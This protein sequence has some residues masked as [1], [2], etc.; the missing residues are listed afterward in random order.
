MGNLAISHDIL[1]AGSDY[2]SCRQRVKRF[3]DRTMLIRY[4]D[5]VV[6]E[7]ESINGTD[8]NFRA[9]IREGLKANQKV[10]GEFLENLKDEGFLS[11]DDIRGLE[12]GYLSKILHTIAHLQDG[13]IGIDSRFYNLEEDSHGVSR[14]LQQKI[15]V[16]PYRYWILKIKGRI[17]PTREEPLDALRTFEGREK[18]LD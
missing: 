5:V 6:I 17:T 14:D 18:G 10:L 13:F 4:D 11:I 16:T 9:R 2:E 1:I 15:T 3:F 12:K 8:G 7:N